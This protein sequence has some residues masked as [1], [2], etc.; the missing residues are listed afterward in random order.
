MLAYTVRCT[1]QDEDLARDWVIWLRD[2]HLAEVV[3]AGAMDAE[4]L[5][6]DPTDD[7]GSVTCQVCYHFPSREAF[8]SYERD[9]ASRLREEGLRNFPLERGL[10]YARSTG[11]VVVRAG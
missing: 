9:H 2:E 10:V 3:A 1:F 4:V 6:L 5:W 8:E 7:E 11:E